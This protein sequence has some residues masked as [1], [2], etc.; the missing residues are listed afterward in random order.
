M[1]LVEVVDELRVEIVYPL[2]KR[3]SFL[4]V[5]NNAVATRV[6]PSNTEELVLINTPVGIF[7][8][9][10]LGLGLGGFFLGLICRFG[11]E[12]F[13]LFPCGAS[14]SAVGMAWL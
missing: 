13:F 6:Q 1:F 11:N 9:S 7:L 8:F 10:I 2:P 4:P 5:A 14:A 3:R 12:F